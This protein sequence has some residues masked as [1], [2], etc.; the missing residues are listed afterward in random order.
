MENLVKK[1][2]RNKTKLAFVIMCDQKDYKKYLKDTD[3]YYNIHPQELNEL[4]S[5]LEILDK[6]NVNYDLALERFFEDSEDIQYDWIHETNYLN[7]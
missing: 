6:N 3:V 4:N 2:N 7:I 1:L 5:T